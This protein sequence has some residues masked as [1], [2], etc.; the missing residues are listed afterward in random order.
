LPVTVTL[1]FED[2]EEELLSLPPP[3]AARRDR[4]AQRAAV[5]NTCFIIRKPIV[6]KLAGIVACSSARPPNSQR[7]LKV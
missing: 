7:S 6:V 2:E 1:K 3:H 4:T 5:F